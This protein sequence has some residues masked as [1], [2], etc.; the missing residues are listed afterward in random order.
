MEAAGEHDFVFKHAFTWFLKMM[1]NQQTPCF[2]HKLLG[3][4]WKDKVVKAIKNP[5]NELSVGL[6]GS[7]LQNAD[8]WEILKQAAVVGVNVCALHLAP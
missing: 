8:V 6:L 4:Y 1:F 7:F 3:N 5:W 2:F